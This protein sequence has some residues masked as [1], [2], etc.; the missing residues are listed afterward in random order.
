MPWDYRRYG[1][2]TD[3][4]H[5]SHLNDLTGDWGCPTRFR[6]ARDEQARQGPGYDLTRPVRGDAACGTAA[7]ETIARA[8][9]N[10]PVRDRILQGPGALTVGEIRRVFVHELDREIG[11][12]AV[13]W[14]DDSRDAMVADRV[15]MIAGLFD[16][17]HEHVG[18][19][20]LVEPAF[21]A[22]VG[23][24]WLQGHI[25]LVY[26]PRD[27]PTGIGIADWKTGAT[28]PD[29]VE[30]DHGWEA[31]VYSSAL[32]TG[33]FLPREA[34]DLTFDDDR[35]V[36]VASHG[37]YSVPHPSKYIAERVCAERVMTHVA[38]VTELDKAVASV[39]EL[40]RF[41]RW[42]DEI[43]HVHLADYVPYKRAGK[44]Q[45]ER[46][47]DLAFY[48]RPHPCK[49]DYVAGDQRGPAWFRVR[50]T[51]H[52]VPRVEHRLRNIVGMV[53]MGRFIDQI[54]DR[55]KRCPYAKDCLNTG[56]GARGDEARDIERAL[57]GVD[58]D[59][60]AEIDDRD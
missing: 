24:Y 28:R 16:E 15:A 55:C 12:R 56:Y 50:L 37:M 51:E 23:S 3:P 33:W 20:L 41:D 2:A 5:K 54:G 25:D 47:E 8:L 36:W 48:N 49:V 11:P 26:R 6:F 7:H 10:P 46:A 59:S 13:E 19:V 31:G 34:L 44:K 52:D 42:P 17:L 27:N 40:C 53:R 22:R 38:S 29:P 14:R 4:I 21:V 60:A 32:H 57:K 18:K 58:V 30:L 1:S 43:R 35:G 39:P 45:I 9:N